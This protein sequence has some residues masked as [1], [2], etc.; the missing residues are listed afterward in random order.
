VTEA[1]GTEVIHG[2]EAVSAVEALNVLHP[3][4]EFRL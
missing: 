3:D 4:A 2:A 1:A